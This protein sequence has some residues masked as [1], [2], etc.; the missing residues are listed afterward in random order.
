MY[1]WIFWFILFAK[2]LPG[3]LRIGGEFFIAPVVVGCDL[4][5]LCIFSSSESES[6]S[7]SE[8]SSLRC[9]MDGISLNASS[10]SVLMCAPIVLFIS[11][12]LLSSPPLGTDKD[13]NCVGLID[14]LKL[15]L[16]S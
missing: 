11:L 16:V 13:N 15:Y 6:E 10:F 2:L 8:S 7:E 4:F 9:R 1:Q 5:C 14:L 3:A 12:L